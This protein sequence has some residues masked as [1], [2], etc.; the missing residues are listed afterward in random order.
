VTDPRHAVLSAL[1]D[2]PHTA[3]V[4]EGRT[5]LDP[6]TVE[7]I[8]AELRAEGVVEQVD[9]NYWRLRARGG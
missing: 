3:A 8:L 9:R 1:A 7:R 4:V 5:G 2:A 6:L